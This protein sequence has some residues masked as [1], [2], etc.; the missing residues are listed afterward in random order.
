MD[1]DIQATLNKH[2]VTLAKQEERIVTLFNNDAR[3]EKSMAE[4]LSEVKSWRTWLLTACGALIT[5]TI[6]LLL[7]LLAKKL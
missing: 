6:L 3:L 4:L 5:S 2:E 7:N 1:D